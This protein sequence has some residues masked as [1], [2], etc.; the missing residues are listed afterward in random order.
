MLTHLPTFPPPRSPVLLSAALAEC[1]VVMVLFFT[2]FKDVWLVGVT[3]GICVAI[4]VG[5]TV[6]ITIWRKKF[7]QKTNKHDND[8]HDKAM[9]SIT[10]F[11]TVKYFAGV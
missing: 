10:N 2:K 1:F 4:Y 11:E 7:R 9:D 6:R 3:I 5:V 8:F